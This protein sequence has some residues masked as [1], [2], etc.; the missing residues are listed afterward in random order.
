MLPAV[1]GNGQNGAWKKQGFVLQTTD[2]NPRYFYFEVFDGKEGKLARYGIEKGGDYTVYFDVRAHEY[3]GRWYNQI[4]VKDVR[5]AT[6]TGATAQQRPTGPSAQATGQQGAQTAQTAQQ[7][8]Q[9]A[10][11]GAQADING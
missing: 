10:Q 11:N 8:A 2:Q 5:R 4:A 3:Q 9:G 7:G 6:T 1:T